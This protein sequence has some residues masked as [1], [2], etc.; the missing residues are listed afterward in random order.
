MIQYS[1]R[2]DIAQRKTAF[3]AM[4]LLVILGIC[5]GNWQL[6]RATYKEDL[7]T[8]IAEKEKLN[9]LSASDKKW[10]LSDALYHQIIIDGYWLNSA[11]VWLDNRPHP[12]GRDPITGITT[13]FNLLM[14][15]KIK[16]K[17]QDFIIWV[18]RGWAPRNFSQRD[19][20]PKVADENAKVQ[21]KGVVF[22]DAGKTYNFGKEVEAKA[23]DGRELIQ[24][25]A[26]ANFSQ[27]INLPY[28]PF[29]VRQDSDVNDGLD[30]H[31]PKMDSGASKHTAYAFQWF[32]LSIMTFLFWLISGIRKQS[33]R[34]G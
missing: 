22:A 33:K 11:G 23:S 30:R 15:L 17:D 32:A 25:F 8:N 27:R 1:I 5:L 28:Q 24:N 34:L 4:I 3:I 9:P 13:G 29:I 14:P 10:E 6:R 21:I 7:A 19:V 31:W 18:N 26:I 2:R 16:V 12:Q 20:V